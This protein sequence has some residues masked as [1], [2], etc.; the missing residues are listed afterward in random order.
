MKCQLCPKPATVHLTEILD[1]Q[2][3]ELHLCQGCAESQQLIKH[4]EINQIGRAHV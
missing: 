2:K 1:G 4:Q 3:K